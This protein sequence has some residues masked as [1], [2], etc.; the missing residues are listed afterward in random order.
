MLSLREFQE[1]TSEDLLSNMG[2]V[3]MESAYLICIQIVVMNINLLSSFFGTACL[4]CWM[5]FSSC[6][7]A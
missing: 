4:F 3:V 5:P 7:V 2:E 6:P 1:Y